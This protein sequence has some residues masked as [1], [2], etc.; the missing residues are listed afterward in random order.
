MTSGRLSISFKFCTESQPHNI[1]INQ[2]YKIGQC[3]NFLQMLIIPQ[4]EEI[5][6]KRILYQNT[7]SVFI[8]LKLHS[9]ILNWLKILHILSIIYE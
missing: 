1:G 5:F 3:N 2:I 6:H 4:H 7:M 8:I 9:N